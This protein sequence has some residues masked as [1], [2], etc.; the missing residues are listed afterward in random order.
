M[1]HVIYSSLFVF[2]F[3]FISKKKKKNLGEFSDEK[4]ERIHQDIKSMERGYQ[5]FCKNSMMVDYCRMF[6]RDA[7]DRAYQRKRKSSHL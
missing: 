7:P 3:R 2:T 4:G 6:Y 1:S 5:S